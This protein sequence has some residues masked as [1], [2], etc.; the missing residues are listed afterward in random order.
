MMST[1]LTG[2]YVQLEDLLALRLRAPLKAS[3]QTRRRSANS[4]QRLSRL[5]GRGVDFAEVRA[6]QPGDDVRSIDWRV[7]ARMNEPHTKVFRE[8]RERPTLLCIDQT[9][10]MFFGSQVRLKSVAAAELAARCAWQALANGDRVGGLIIGSSDTTLAKPK[11]SARAVARLLGQLSE[12]NQALNRQTP[13]ND[14]QQIGRELQHLRRLAQTNHRVVVITDFLPRGT[15]WLDN[16]RALAR[17]NDVIAIQIIDPMEREVPIAEQFMV[18]DGS[19]RVTFD[20][21]DASL[22]RAYRSRFAQEQQQLKQS[23]TELGIRYLEA[24]TAQPLDT[25]GIWR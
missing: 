12:H 4:G 9:R 21:A 13:A 3:R 18:S 19:R 15:F 20:A 25:L 6:Y 5:R 8:E 10:S 16:L 22:R 1:T 7:T 11:R 24:S 17:H 23:L 14:T 2:A